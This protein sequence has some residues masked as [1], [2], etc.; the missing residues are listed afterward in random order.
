LPIKPIDFNQF[1][2]P[3][4]NSL[5]PQHNARYCLS[6]AKMASSCKRLVY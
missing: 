4:S 5:A 6:F 2:R 3:A 1:H